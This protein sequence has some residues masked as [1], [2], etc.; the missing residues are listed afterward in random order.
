MNTRTWQI[1]PWVI[2]KPAMEGRGFYLLGPRLALMH[3]DGAPEDLGRLDEDELASLASEGFLIEAEEA[4]APAPRPA[5]PAHAGAR[6]AYIVASEWVEEARALAEALERAGSLERWQIVRGWP[7]Q[8][9]SA[10]PALVMLIAAREEGRPEAL[11]RGRVPPFRVL[12]FGEGAE[13]LHAGPVFERPE[14]VTSYAQAASAWSS[15]R[16]LRRL[17]FGEQ[18][19]L[20]LLLRLR[21]SPDAVASAVEALLRAPRSSCVLVDT[22]QVVAPWTALIESPVTPGDLLRTQ[23]WSKGMLRDLS[24]FQGEACQDVFFGACLGPCDEDAEL[25]AKFGKG[26][27]AEEAEQTT[28]GEAVE[29]FAA[30]RAARRPTPSRS[31][32]T[33]SRVYALAD[34]HPFGAP[35]DDYLRRGSPPI[36]MVV[37]IDELTGERVA[38]PE[39][40]VPE[41][42]WPPS[43]EYLTGGTTSGLAAFP[44]RDGAIVRASMEILERHNFYPAF[45]HQREGVRLLPSQLPDGARKADLLRLV[46]SFLP[47][48]SRLWLL[49]YP[50][51]LELPIVHAFLWDERL[52]A[53]S[54]GSGSGLDVTA[55]ALK[56]T[57]EALQLRMQHEHVQRSGSAEG[58]NH[59]YAAWAS[60]HVCDTLKSYLQAQRTGRADMPM[61]EGD[62][63]LLGHTKGKLRRSGAAML[64]A[65]LP[66][67][68][69]GWS[70]VRV[71]LPGITSHG[72]PSA[73][74]G[75]RRLLGA[76]FR[77]PVPT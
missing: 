65:D 69:Q 20:S 17:D 74:A 55:A 50:D 59:A 7:E 42:Y 31:S 49:S 10:E 47:E 67:P 51:E 9:T 60:P 28:V 1:P 29:R 5:E 26:M 11:L 76:R 43:G 16:E 75:G 32:E 72:A 27:S 19:P 14:D 30:W 64:V 12:W 44:S 13:G 4:V 63:E 39:C 18:W 56:A 61:F 36:P 38:S 68:V 71:L 8:A 73:S 15:T 37:M 66:C 62:A 52:H 40:L 77:Y 35:W 34:F 58:E 2:V 22:G 24:V 33:P 70:A 3:L 46:D 41:P 25:E 21:R 48:V 23:R 57:L 6:Q 54:R 53:M 45:L